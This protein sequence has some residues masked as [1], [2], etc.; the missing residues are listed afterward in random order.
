MDAALLICRVSM[1]F[2]GDPVLLVGLNALLPP[3]HLIEMNGDHLIVNTPD[4]RYRIVN[5]V[6]VPEAQY[7]FV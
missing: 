6:L 3:D 7:I 2:R 4:G 1:L 5:G